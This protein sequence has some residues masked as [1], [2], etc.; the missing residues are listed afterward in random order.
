MFSA[1]CGLET[2]SF[3][4][5]QRSGYLSPGGFRYRCLRGRGLSWACVRT[6]VP[7]GSGA[8]TWGKGCSHRGHA[9]LLGPPSPP[10]SF[11][12]FPCRPSVLHGPCPDAPSQGGTQ[13]RRGRWLL[14]S[15][16]SLGRRS[17]SSS[18]CPDLGEFSGCPPP[19]TR[20][21]RLY[22]VEPGLQGGLLLSPEAFSAIVAGDGLA[23]PTGAEG[24]EL[25]S[26]LRD[27]PLRA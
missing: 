13:S 22:L 12:Q 9:P 2:L 24:T 20:P 16:N 21:S 4:A 23:G 1:R 8:S 14:L 7:Q 6:L 11:P 26:G 3:C 10:P 25:H 17:L 15:V 18:T 5:C 19:P 27:E